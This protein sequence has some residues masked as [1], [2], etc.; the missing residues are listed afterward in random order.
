MSAN[1]SPG[2]KPGDF[3]VQPAFSFDG[4][5]IV[6]WT[7]RPGAFWEVIRREHDRVSAMGEAQRLAS[8]AG[9]TAWAYEPDDMHLRL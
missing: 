1:T 3:V 9:M 5:K 8:E 6:R 7:D 4:W 2:P